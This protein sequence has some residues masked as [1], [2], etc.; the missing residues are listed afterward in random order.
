MNLTTVVVLMTGYFVVTLLS[1]Y[2]GV[3]THRR[4]LRKAIVKIRKQRN[5]D[6]DFHRD[7]LL[8]HMRLEE[9]RKH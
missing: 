2:W 6:L 1:A 8:A 5:R 4:S 9:A 3:R 7:S